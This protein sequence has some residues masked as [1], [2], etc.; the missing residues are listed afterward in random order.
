MYL[1]LCILMML[2]EIF[3][4]Q[5]VATYQV[6]LI[7][8]FIFFISLLSSRMALASL[9]VT[10]SFLV[11]CHFYSIKKPGQGFVVLSGLLILM[12]LSI[13]VNPVSRFHSWIEPMS[14][15][16]SADQNTPHWNSVN[17]R[18]LSWEAS[19]DA[20]RTFWP[21]GTG[22]GDGQLVLNQYYSNLGILGYNVNSH[23][24]YLQT[25][26]EL[27]VPGIASLLFCLYGPLFRAF[28]Q[29]PLHFSFM[30][31]FGMMCLTES[32]L[33]RPKGI[34]FFAMF[35]SSFLSLETALHDR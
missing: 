14:T 28:R 31:L 32:M 9:T 16:L 3:D 6:V 11:L 24:Q 29:N 12:F 8:V 26:I 22:T 33:V 7:V 19:L 15:P 23:N 5:R 27:G 10:L 25:F 2:Q 4:R 17:L 30:V 21:V 20:S 35:Q 13:W 18:L 34:A 1:I